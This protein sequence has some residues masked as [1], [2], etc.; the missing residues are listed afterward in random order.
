MPPQK[1]DEASSGKQWLIRWVKSGNVRSEN[2]SSAMPLSPAPRQGQRAPR[3]TRQ[4]TEARRTS[5]LLRQQPGQLLGRDH[6]VN[7]VV[8]RVSY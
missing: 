4:D 5:P 7:Q 6:I 3:A 8:R 2:I 1:F